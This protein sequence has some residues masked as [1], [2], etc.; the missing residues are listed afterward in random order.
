MSDIDSSPS[1]IEFKGFNSD[2]AIDIPNFNIPSS[3][4]QNEILIILGSVALS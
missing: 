3:A 4:S 1:S 2:F